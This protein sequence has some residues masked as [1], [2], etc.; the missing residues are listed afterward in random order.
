ML[1]EIEANGL[2]PNIAQE[3]LPFV[4]AYARLGDW[5]AAETLSREVHQ[6]HTRND[7]M[8]CALWGELGRDFEA[9]AAAQNARATV[10]EFAGCEN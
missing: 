7:A 3:W 5:T 4:E 1:I 8:L 6:S 2:G 10:N 9:D